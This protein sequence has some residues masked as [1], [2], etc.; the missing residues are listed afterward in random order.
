MNLPV[1]AKKVIQ[2]NLT[3]KFPY[4]VLKLILCSSCLYL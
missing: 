1:Q 2:D 3:E 4:Q